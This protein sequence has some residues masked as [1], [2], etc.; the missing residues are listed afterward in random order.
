MAGLRSRSVSAVFGE[1]IHMYIRDVRINGMTNPVG[2]DFRAVK[3]SWK[4]EEFAAP[5][6]KNAKIE[7]AAD[8]DFSEL[9]CVKEG[10]ELKSNC[11]Q[12]PMEV[13]PCTRYYVRVTVTD[14]ADLTAVND[15][16]FFES[17]K[18]GGA[19][20]GKWI[21]TQEEDSFHPVFLKTFTCGKTIRKARLYI[22]GLGLYEAYI[23]GEKAGDEYLA[24]FFND[25]NYDVQYQT[26]DVTGLLEQQNEIEVMLG[27]GWYNGRFGLIP[28]PNASA[29][30]A[31]IAE[32]HIFYED[33]SEEIIATDENWNYRGSDIRDSSIYDGEI[34]DRMLWSDRDNPKKAVLLRNPGRK[35]TARFSVPLGVNETLL[36]KE[37]ITTPAGETVLDFGQNFVGYVSFTANFEKGTEILL[38]YGE[39]L[40]KGCFYHANYRSAKSEFRYI[41]AGCREEARPHF[42]FFGGRYVKVSGWPMDRPLTG[43][44][45]TGNVVYSRLERTGFIETSNPK[46][47]RLVSN[48]LWGQKGN[49]LDV[50][51]DCPQRDER[52]GW[53]GDANVFSVTASYNMDTRAF[54]DKYMYDL[55]VAQQQIGGAGP[56]MAPVCGIPM[57]GGCVWGDVMAAIPNNMY[58]FFGDEEQL[59]HYYRNMKDW[60][61]YVTRESEK[62][63]SDYLYDFGF[64]F[65][66]WLALDGLTEQ[67]EYGQTDNGF[68]ASCY[69]Y[70]S[71]CMTEKAA[72][73]CGFAEDAAHYHRLAE[74]IRRAI[75]TEYFSAS[76][77][78]AI[79][80]QT[81]YIVALKW[82]IYKDKKKLTDGLKARLYKDAYKIKGGFVG[83]TSLCTVLAENGFEKEALRFLLN[84]EYPGWLYCVNL[85]AT[86]IWERWN[87]LLEDGSIS[88]T[89]MNSLNH[90]SYGSVLEYIYKDIAG[91]KPAEPGFR[92]IAL[93]PQI[94]GA[95][96][97]FRCSYD[98]ASGRYEC[99]WKVERDGLVS[100]HIEIPFNCAARLQLPMTEEEERL[101]EAGNYDF[102][103]RPEKDLNLRFDDESL[104]LDYATC[105]EAMAILEAKAPSVCAAIQKKDLEVLCKPLQTVNPYTG[106]ADMAME[107]V[108]KMISRIE[109]S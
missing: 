5:R 55:R 64:H 34:L 35:L 27:K 101:L 67:S 95:F 45:F 28:N 87:S 73:V 7:I 86:T 63:S 84:E 20:S 100:L 31:L 66:D 6:Q 12:M 102:S 10:R 32:L 83:A 89:G 104:C 11:E 70:A 92:S 90:Y 78:L 59:A 49:F 48:C 21:G 14:E 36:V 40:Q 17:A 68:I 97:Q 54:Y 8:P 108:K 47:N 41:S 109:W 22:C 25:Y 96:R 26:Y 85:G 57:P 98:S 46:I 106:E 88:G 3:V 80:T 58:E 18:M 75:L 56:A 19:W 15:T 93:Q 30:F 105:K 74:N 23:N 9:V 43:K 4:V 94:T 24:P 71:V 16:A 60:V 53:T 76:G 50:P 62:N 81:G 77:R 38:E 13:S 61:D 33:G 69:Y 44:E 52:L 37:V 91:I 51:T 1:K 103:Y 2:Y 107:E 72:E 99:S 82:G 39:T 29:P 79:D 42:T 65:A